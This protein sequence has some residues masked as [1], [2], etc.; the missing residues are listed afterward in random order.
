MS[1]NYFQQLNNTLQKV[2]NIDLAKKK[3]TYFRWKS[4][5]N[6]DKLLFEFETNVRKTDGKVLYAAT[7]D[8]AIEHLNKLIKNYQNIN[9]CEHLAVKYL[10]RQTNTK[11]S[12]EI[13]KPEVMVVG[14]KFFIANS[15]NIFIN[16]KDSK[17]YSQLLLAKKIV[18]IAGIDSMLASQADLPLAKMLYSIYETA[19]LTYPAEI[20]LRSGKPRGIN[21]EVHTII[22]DDMRSNLLHYPEHRLLFNLLNFEMATVCSRQLLSDSKGFWKD[23][24]SLEYLL[25]AFMDNTSSERIIFDNYGY[26][27]LQNYLPY[28]VDLAENVMDMRSKLV[29]QQA[30]VWNKIFNKSSINYIQNSKKFFEPSQFEKFETEQIFSK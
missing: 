14:A 20:I 12:D 23:I 25:H 22:V 10:L 7:N 15:G 28:E 30:N 29:P 26:K 24:N 3:L 9:F 27:A 17:T 8:I 13:E 16:F 21:A 19:Q 1:Q 4:T 5:E 6:L 18:V 2:K 11:L